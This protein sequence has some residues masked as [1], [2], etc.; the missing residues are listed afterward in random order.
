MR[1]RMLSRFRLKGPN[2]GRQHVADRLQRSRLRSTSPLPAHMLHPTRIG[3]WI[4]FAG[5][6][7]SLLGKPQLM[8][9]IIQLDEAH[10]LDLCKRDV[11]WRI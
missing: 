7:Q 11:H 5:F 9:Q 6:A 8:P 3:G 1:R 2:M 4:E 10:A